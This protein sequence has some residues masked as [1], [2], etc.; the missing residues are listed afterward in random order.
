VLPLFDGYDMSKRRIE[1]LNEQLRREV[2]EIVQRE[3]KDPRIGALTI[4][5]ARV[6]RDLQ[7]ARLF[8]SVSGSADAQRATLAGLD[9]AKAFI[10]SALASRLELRHIPELRFQLDETLDHAMRIERLLHE[11]LPPSNDEAPDEG[12]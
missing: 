6:S 7:L 10:R 11:V 9:A 12:E 2:A 3:V 1:R 4:T 8:V 5:G